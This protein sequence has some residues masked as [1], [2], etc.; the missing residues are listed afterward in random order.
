M[1][2]KVMLTRSEVE[3]LNQ[4]NREYG[5]VENDNVVTMKMI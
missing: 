3:S 2:N 4:K 5:I 1:Y